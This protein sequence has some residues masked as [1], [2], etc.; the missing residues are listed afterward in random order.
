MSDPKFYIGE[1]VIFGVR[2][3]LVDAGEVVD[4]KWVYNLTTARGVRTASMIHETDIKKMPAIR[5][6]NT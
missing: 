2:M 3:W 6:S 1:C 5:K 4:D